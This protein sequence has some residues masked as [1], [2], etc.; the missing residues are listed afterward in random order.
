MIGQNLADISCPDS[1]A[2][3]ADGLKPL[4]IHTSSL[5]EECAISQF[6]QFHVKLKEGSKYLFHK[7]TT[8]YMCVLC[9]RERCSVSYILENITIPGCY[10]IL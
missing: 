9:T 1:A 4:A 6:R 3:I 2:K 5:D 10:D 8:E 7:V